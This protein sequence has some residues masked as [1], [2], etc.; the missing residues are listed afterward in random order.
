MDRLLAPTAQG[1]TEGTILLNGQPIST[2]N[3]ARVAAYVE[4][5]DIVLGTLLELDNR[6]R[7]AST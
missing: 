6:K 2:E 7:P 3:F 1:E 4:Q 5:Q